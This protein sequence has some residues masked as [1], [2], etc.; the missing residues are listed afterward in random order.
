[1]TLDIIDVVAAVVIALVGN[2]LIGNYLLQ[3]ERSNHEQRL[4]H[5]RTELETKIRTLQAALDR[6]ILVHRVQFEAEFAALREIWSKVAAV[7]ASMGLVRPMMDIVPANETKE[8][9][10]AR[11]HERFSTFNNDLGDLIRAVDYQSPFIPREIYERLETLIQTARAE[12]SEVAVERPD[13]ER[14][15]ITDWFKRGRESYLELCAEAN[16]VSDLIR[17]RLERLTVLD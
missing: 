14:L 6:T 7:R 16:R 17:A 3:R 15:G 13:R 8:Q 2:G 1:M 12:L 9:R 10:E 4:E 11:E 5:L